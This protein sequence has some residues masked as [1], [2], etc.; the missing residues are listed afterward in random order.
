M[1]VFFEFFFSR[2]LGS[3]PGWVVLRFFIREECRVSGF[4]IWIHVIWPGVSQ[5]RS[6]YL[7]AFFDTC[8][9]KAHKN[10]VA[11]ETQYYYI[12]FLNTTVSRRVC[13]ILQ[14]WLSPIH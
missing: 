13:Q 1:L 9:F 10:D 5:I 8:V 7:K 12:V 14:R 11:L 3:G 2:N 6:D 4:W